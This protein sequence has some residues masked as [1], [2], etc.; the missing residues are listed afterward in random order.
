MVGCGHCS[1]AV[2]LDGSL[3]VWGTGSFGEEL[4]PKKF[5]LNS[6]I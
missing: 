2:G 3:F 4:V 1:A 6:K 5:R